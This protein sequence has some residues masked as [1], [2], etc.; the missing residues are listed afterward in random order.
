MQTGHYLCIRCQSKL[1]LLGIMK[2]I[3]LALLALYSLGGYYTHYTF[4]QLCPQWGWLRWGISSL[5]ALAFVAQ[6]LTVFGRLLLPVWLLRPL[7]VFG[8]VWV[9]VFLYLLM[10]ALF[11]GML[12]IVPIVRSCLVDNKFAAGVFILVVA[13]IFAFGNWK[14][15]VKERV[16]LGITLTKP[17]TRPFKIVGVSDLH[18]GYTIGRVELARWVDMINQEGADLILIAGDVVDNDI[19]PIL[20]EGMQHELSRLNARLGVYAVLGNHEYI[21]NEASARFFF[22]QT[23][24]KLLRD[25]AELVADELY[26]VGRDDR[27]NR[28]RRSLEE[29]LSPLDHSRPILVLDHQPRELD[30]VARLGVD[31]QFSGHTHRGQVFPANILVDRMYELSHGYLAKGKSHFYVSS[32]LGIWGGKFR[33]GSQSEYLVLTLGGVGS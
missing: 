12:K 21:G 10:G 23:S 3:F 18:L 7:V 26:I 20:E 15:H 1:V 29:L 16:E 28:N 27:T 24:I 32:G 11:I 17:L 14:Y 30:E 19:R 2:M 9:F 33:I 22:E 31:F 6:V 5:N 4:T 25:E 8:N 13:T